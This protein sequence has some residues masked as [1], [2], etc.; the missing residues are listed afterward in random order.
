MTKMAP[1]PPFAHYKYWHAT[2][3]RLH[4]HT[5]RRISSTCTSAPTISHIDPRYFAAH[6]FL[7]H[8]PHYISPSPNRSSLATY[9]RR[10]SSVRSRVSRGNSAWP[11][12]RRSYKTGCKARGV[13]SAVLQRRNPPRERRAFWSRE[14]G[15]VPCVRIYS[16]I[17]RIGTEWARYCAAAVVV[18]MMM[19]MMILVGAVVTSEEVV[20]ASSCETDRFLFSHRGLEMVSQQ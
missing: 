7:S 12:R 16:H 5:A 17:P 14:N 15:S 1:P 6:F 8:M 18:A 13:F 2:P 11:S 19:T 3:I 10:F 4:C 9:C 20:A